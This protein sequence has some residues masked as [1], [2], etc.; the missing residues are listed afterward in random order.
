MQ[1]PK[2]A[3]AKNPDPVGVKSKGQA[4]LRLPLQAP[5]PPNNPLVVVLG[6]SLRVIDAMKLDT[7]LE[8]APSQ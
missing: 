2:P 8:T 1:K 5:L 7:L 6:E 3:A 4:P